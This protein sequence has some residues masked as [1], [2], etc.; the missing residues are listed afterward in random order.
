MLPLPGKNA[1]VFRL[2]LMRKNNNKLTPYEILAG[3]F[4]VGLGFS[5]QSNTIGH[6]DHPGEM[7]SSWYD[8]DVPTP[9]MKKNKPNTHKISSTS[10]KKLHNTKQHVHNNKIKKNHSRVTLKHAKVNHYNAQRTH[11]T[12]IKV[13]HNT[14]N[15]KILASNKTLHSTKHHVSHAKI[16]KHYSKATLKHAKVNH[17]NAQ[18]T[19]H[20]PIK[21][22]HNTYNHKILASNKTLHSTKHHVSQAKIMKTQSLRNL[23]HANATQFSVQQNLPPIKVKPK[24]TKITSQTHGPIQTVQ[25]RD[26]HSFLP[27]LNFNGHLHLQGGF[28]SAKS[29]T[30]TQNISIPGLIGEQFT[31]ND[32]N[33]INGLG[34]IGYFVSGSQKSNLNLSYGLNIYYLAQ[35]SV[36]GDVY[37]EHLF[38]NLGY[39]YNITNIPIYASLQSE[40]KT[41]SDR[42]SIIFDMGIGPNIIQTEFSETS[43]D[44][45]VTLPEHF[46][47]NKTNVQFTAMGGIGARINHAFDP[48][49]FGCGYRFFYLGN[50]EFNNL[51]NNQVTTLTSN[52]NY[53]HALVCEVKV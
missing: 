13:K 20:A 21:I 51:T 49:Q 38:N 52:V 10:N 25:P 4:M 5:A 18:R 23:K 7:A 22:K 44:G 6:Q 19:H 36:S 46:F 9:Q 28:F 37:Q 14:H 3:L 2:Y 12:P 31:I 24:A 30:G 33:K 34:G 17:Y 53:A 42:F 29:Q 26:Y 1:V 45:G 41:P 40:I 16:N 27:K 48:F 43:L 47:G 32:Q 8:D 15:H 35:S 11:H 50:P 39:E